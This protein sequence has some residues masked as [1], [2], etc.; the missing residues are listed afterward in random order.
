MDAGSGALSLYPFTGMQCQT[1]C[2]ACEVKLKHVTPRSLEPDHV[3]K[4]HPTTI[5]FT[6][7]IEAKDA[8]ELGLWL[9][10]ESDSITGCADGRSPDEHTITDSA[11]DGYQQLVPSP[12]VRAEVG[13]WGQRE[14]P[15]IPNDANRTRPSQ[16]TKVFGRLL[17]LAL[18]S[19]IGGLRSNRPTPQTRTVIRR[20]PKVVDDQSRGSNDRKAR[21]SKHGQLRPSASGFQRWHTHSIT[22]SKTN[23][24]VDGR[25]GRNGHRDC[26]PDCRRSAATL[27]A[28]RKC[29]SKTPRRRR[30]TGGYVA[31][32][33]NCPFFPRCRAP[34]TRAVDA[35]AHR[36]LVSIRRLGNSE[37]GELFDTY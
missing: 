28:A 33:M 19:T 5:Q 18:A 16:G 17:G 7:T 1:S 30:A 36:R 29:R 23:F 4:I 3:G 10:T 31:V 27:G 2:S 13:R 8:R 25:G 6:T 32:H 34:I 21:D 37:N 20:R 12:P 35:A 14:G 22:V 26:P 9:G 24:I 15:R 11:L